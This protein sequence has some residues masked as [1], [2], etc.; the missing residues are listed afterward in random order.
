[1]VK[2]AAAT[3]RYKQIHSLS[4]RPAIDPLPPSA[5]HTAIDFNEDPEVIA[6]KLKEGNVDAYALNP[7]DDA[8]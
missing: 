5:K 7:G 1:M 2:Y 6:Q 4:R 3:G 8:A